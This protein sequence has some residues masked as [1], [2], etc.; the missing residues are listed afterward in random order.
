MVYHQLQVVLQVTA[1]CCCGSCHQI[2]VRHAPSSASLCVANHFQEE[3][4]PATQLW[5][6]VGVRVD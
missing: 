2:K 5:G 6:L 1:R 3:N 4:S